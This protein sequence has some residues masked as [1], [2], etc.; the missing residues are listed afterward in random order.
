MKLSSESFADGQ[1]IPPEFAFCRIDPKK[2]SFF[3]ESRSSTVGKLVA[4][5]TLQTPCG[6][7]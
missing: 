1:P 2:R 6:A 5:G 4:S 7:T 3:H